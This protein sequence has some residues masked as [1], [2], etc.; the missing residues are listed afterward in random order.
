M[1]T[2][3][4]LYIGEANTDADGNQ[5][6]IL[7][8]FDF[9]SIPAG[10]VINSATLYLTQIA[11]ESSNNR[12]AV[13]Y[14]C[15]RNWTESG[16]TYNKYDGVNNWGTAGARATTDIDTTN[17]LGTRAFSGSEA[18]GEKAFSLNTT[19]ITKMINGSYSNY[20]FVVTLTNIPQVNDLY[21]FASSGN[22]TAT[23]RPKIVIDYSVPTPGGSSVIWWF[24][25]WL[26][27]KKKERLFSQ[28]V[29]I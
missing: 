5:N 22:A 18:G 8:K 29:F 13:V 14:R 20:G 7:V 1:G 23:N 26:E 19:E 16:A 2:N 3:T 9:S 6:M 12:T 21:R 17:V 27:Q 4:S 25:K 11:E 10:A 24:K 15:L 28:P